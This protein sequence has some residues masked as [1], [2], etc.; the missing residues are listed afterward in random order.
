MFEVV[1]KLTEKEFHELPRRWIVERMFFWSM[2][3]LRL[4][5]NF[6]Q[7]IETVECFIYLAM[8]RLVMK[9]LATY[10]QLLK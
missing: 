2:K 9:R 8:V 5:G 3:D 10:Q 7:L 1:D 4:A 6:E